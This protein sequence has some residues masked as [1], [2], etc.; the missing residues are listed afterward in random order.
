MLQP[1]LPARIWQEIEKL[2][3]FGGNWPRSEQAR[4]AA[5]RMDMIRIRRY[6]LGRRDPCRQNFNSKLRVCPANRQ[7]Q[8]MYLVIIALNTMNIKKP[9][10]NLGED[11]RI[12][13]RLLSRPDHIQTAI[14]V[15]AEPNRL[16]RERG[17]SLRKDQSA[18]TRKPIQR[19]TRLLSQHQCIRKDTPNRRHLS[20]SDQSVPDRIQI[21]VWLR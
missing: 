18:T 12:Q 1:A 13:S 3:N 20:T 5:K 16:I 21:F 2:R 8:S 17:L 10:K 14:R 15:M 6:I 11:A 4:M 9:A 19:T 7:D